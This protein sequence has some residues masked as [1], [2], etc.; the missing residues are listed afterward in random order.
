MDILKESTMEIGATSARVVS[1]RGAHIEYRRDIDGIRALSIIVV[2]LF[3]AG[4]PHMLGGFIGVD[5]F[6]VI[7]GYLIGTLLIKEI[8]SD[9]FS[10]AKFYARRAKRI[11]PPLFTVLAFSSVVAVAFWSPIELEK[12]AGYS[13]ATVLS[14]SN[15]LFARAAD[16]F[17]A[18]T[19][20]NPLLMTWS[21]G[22][23]EQFYIVFPVLLLSIRRLTTSYQNL[24][25][26]SV[27]ACS[28]V[29]SV[30]ATDN[31]PLPSFYLLPTRAW[32]L[33][34]GILVVLFE[35]RNRIALRGP[36]ANWLGLLG[37]VL[38]LYPVFTYTKE[39]RFPGVGA[40]SPVIGAVLLIC[41]RD[42]WV[43]RFLGCKPMVGIGLVSYSWYL[44][45]WPLLSF[46][47]SFADR[48]LPLSSALIVCVLALI[49]ATLTYYIVE[50]KF[51][52]SATRPAH[53]L[54][55]YAVIMITFSACDACVF[56]V[57]GLPARYD[58]LLSRYESEIEE[59]S[60]DKCLIGYGRVHVKDGAVCRWPASLPTTI[61]VFGD[62]HAAAITPA[63]RLK[64]TSSGG[65]LVQITK[66]SC[67]P[68]KGV[69][70]YVPS[71][72]MHFLECLRFNQEALA[73]I[74]ADRRITTVVLAAFWSIPFSEGSYQRPGQE[75][76]SLTLAESR[77]NFLLG[78]EETIV[79]LRNDGKE[80][81]VLNDAP[82]LPIDPVRNVLAHVIPGRG[83]LAA[84]VAGAR[85]DY[86][87]HVDRLEATM[88]DTYA[89]SVIQRQ[90][91]G[92]DGV[93]SFNL[94]NG[95]CDSTTCKFADGVDLYY[96][97]RQHLSI[98]G[99]IRATS[100]MAWDAP[101]RNYSEAIGSQGSSGDVKEILG[102]NGK[103][104]Q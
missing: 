62:S 44:W 53:L 88:N 49:L 8:S 96:V 98:A 58:P 99:A 38:I 78:L 67:P 102:R 93:S 50:S 46:A 79:L 77:A 39:T 33:G 34:G 55:R 37:A 54:W 23:E 80:V 20:L 47:R 30:W 87:L 52:K 42:G 11:L 86:R 14:I 21:L 15:V 84:L 90:T 65:G 2:V 17:A 29:L 26:G 12:Y 69:S 57:R 63:L 18:G 94:K 95:L 36:V 100:A 32:E 101:A 60:S 19:E 41:S 75:G 25:L 9:S 40:L 31:Y 59:L 22:V 43:N 71:H 82:Y 68:L 76:Q 1:G 35:R 85:M 91:T 3:H 13:A 5:V 104:L 70:R 56:A 7:S 4:V 27:I 45:H 61:A 97:D 10:F 72:P 73:S 24:I 89:D 51:R 64:A 66:S 81:I 6:F 28:F 74:T 92:I 16:Y 48:E 83:A 103:D